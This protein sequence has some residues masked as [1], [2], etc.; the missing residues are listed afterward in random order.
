MHSSEVQFQFLPIRRMFIAIMIRSFTI[1]N[2]VLFFTLM[3]IVFTS[4]FFRNTY[5]QRKTVAHHIIAIILILSKSLSPGTV[6]SCCETII[7]SASEHDISE[8]ILTH[9][10]QK[11][12]N[13][14]LAYKF[15]QLFLPACILL[16]V[17]PLQSKA[18][19]NLVYRNIDT[20]VKNIA[21]AFTVPDSD[22]IG[23]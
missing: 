7:I 11:F 20:F 1:H 10:C 22:N 5:M 9:Y 12:G 14:I 6:P 13:K 18:P 3:F 21:E 23:S 16:T 15:Y 8:N 2:I 19:S 17:G 4:T